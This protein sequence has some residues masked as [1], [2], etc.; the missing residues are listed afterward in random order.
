MSE[1]FIDFCSEGCWRVGVVGWLDVPALIGVYGHDYCVGILCAS[2][3]KGLQ[4]T[5]VCGVM[6]QEIREDSVGFEVDKTVLCGKYVV[7]GLV[8]VLCESTGKVDP[9]VV[10]RVLGSGQWRTSM[11]T[12]AHAC[13]GPEYA[14][15]LLRFHVAK[16][17]L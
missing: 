1:C 3:E 9:G 5:V 13:K 4:S 17:V 8:C 11:L 12:R 15:C 6:C 10:K 7:A 14:A 2:E 16:R